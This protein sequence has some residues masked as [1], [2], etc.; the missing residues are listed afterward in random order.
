MYLETFETI[1]EAL[2]AATGIE[3][4]PLSEGGV[5]ADFASTVAFDLAKERKKAWRITKKPTLC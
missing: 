4:P 3:Y 1:R 5:H 2:A